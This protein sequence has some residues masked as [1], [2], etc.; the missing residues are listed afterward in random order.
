MS[1]REAGQST[2]AAASS[3]ST[4]PYDGYGYG[5]ER[6]CSVKV[7]LEFVGCMLLDVGHDDVL[8]SWIY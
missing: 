5:C 2:M 8:S 1:R 4:L 3:S 7:K 6:L